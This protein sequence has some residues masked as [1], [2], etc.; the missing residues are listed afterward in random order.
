MAFSEGC[1]KAPSFLIDNLLRKPSEKGSPPPKISSTYSPP[2]F[3]SPTSLS[4]ARM[5]GISQRHMDLAHLQE[6]HRF[7]PPLPSHFFPVPS[8]PF[9]Y[10]PAA[11]V[12]DVR[13]FMQSCMARMEPAASSHYGLK[14][15]PHVH[16]NG[17]GPYFHSSRPIHKRKGGQVRFS[18]DQTIDLEKKFKSQKYLTPAE[19]KKL[20]KTLTLSERQIKTWF[21]NR[22]AK[23]R[24][25]KNDPDDQTDE[26]PLSMED[27]A[28]KPTSSASSSIS[29]NTS[30]AITEAE[31][32]KK[33][34]SVKGRL[35]SENR[36]RAASSA[37][38]SSNERRPEM[39]CHSDSE[40]L[41][42]DDSD[43][44]DVDGFNGDN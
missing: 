34:Q 16:M 18:N 24:R 15:L 32:T 12:Q 11:S 41:C 40:S 20:A 1:R 28:A 9:P 35:S 2:S 7:Y 10:L 25:L 39:M 29:S 30:T 44:V 36:A 17:M 42:S 33:Q 6:G 26:P 14:S 8:L 5:Y 4:D 21:Q 43:V 38:L 22:R 31:D 19:R 37:T 3:V 27:V 23:W 13:S